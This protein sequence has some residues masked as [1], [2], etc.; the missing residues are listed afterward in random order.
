MFFRIDLILL[1][2]DVVESN[3]YTEP[4]VRHK[5]RPPENIFKVCFSNKAMELINLLK[6]LPCNF[7]YTHCIVQ[8]TKTYKFFYIQF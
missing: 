5:K 3:L 1:V 4:G 2:T 8:F 6:D 7:V